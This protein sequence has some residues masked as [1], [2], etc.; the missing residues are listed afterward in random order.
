MLSCVTSNPRISHT[1]QI[2]IHLPIYVW[3]KLTPSPIH[4]H[5]IV[6]YFKKPLL[7]KSNSTHPL[8]NFLNQKL[9]SHYNF[10]QSKILKAVFNFSFLYFFKHFRKVGWVGKSMRNQCIIESINVSVNDYDYDNFLWLC[11]HCIKN[12]VWKKIH[13]QLLMCD[14]FFFH[15]SFL[16]LLLTTV[17]Q[18]VQALCYDFLKILLKF[19]NVC[20]L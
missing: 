16:S 14:V 2:T 17:L 18:R 3:V 11:F 15:F 19:L 12:L 10:L 7:T 4:P 20:I 8:R 6:S 9:K 13:S 5:Q 1:S